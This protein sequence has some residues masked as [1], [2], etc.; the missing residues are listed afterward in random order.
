MQS[1]EINTRAWRTLRLRILDR[2]D[3]TCYRC[4][5]D[6]TTVDHI[7][8]RAY[9]GTNEDSNLAACCTYCNYSSGGAMGRIF[10]KGRPPINLPSAHLSPMSRER[11]VSPWA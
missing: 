5:K 9:G 4:G 7:Q 8:P 11:P 1:N 2:D 6:A 3:H 10:R